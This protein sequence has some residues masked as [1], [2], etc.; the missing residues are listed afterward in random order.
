MKEKSILCVFRK[1][2]YKDN[3]KPAYWVGHSKLIS[4]YID[5]LFK[6]TTR[7]DEKEAGIIRKTVFFN[8]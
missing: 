6:R 5:E 8:L 2:C 3:N 4:L 7:F 1:K